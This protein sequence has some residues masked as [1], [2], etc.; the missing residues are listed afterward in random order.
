M[1]CGAKF[2]HCDDVSV[3]SA[4]EGDIT[5][6][7]LESMGKSRSSC[8]AKFCH[9]ETAD[10]GIIID[11]QGV[12]DRELLNSIE[13]RILSLLGQ[14]MQL[15]RQDLDPEDNFVY[16]FASHINDLQSRVLARA[17]E[18]AYPNLYGEN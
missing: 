17:A 16:E 15:Y 11:T 7:V 5:D 13:H 10:N 6:R 14:C 3:T 12:Y 2:C 8:G 1:S 18:R 9:C 4:L